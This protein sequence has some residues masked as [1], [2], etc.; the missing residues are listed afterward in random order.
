M[1][2]FH[3]IAIPH[4][5]VLEG[6]LTMDVFAA[7]LWQVT[8]NKGPEEY[9]DAETFFGK[10]YLT[11]GL[12]NLLDIVQKRLEGRGGDPV[13]QIQTP[14]GGG[15]THSLIAMYHKAAE[16]RAKTVAIVGTAPGGQKTLWGWLEEQLTGK[17]TTLSGLVSPGKIALMNLLEK[18]QPVLILMD[19]ILE[20]AVKA[21][22]TKV[23]ESTLAAQTLAFMQEL[24]ETVSDLEKT[25]LVVTIPSSVAPLYDQNAERLFKGLQMVAG[26][27]EKIYTPID[28]SEIASIIRSRLFSSCDVA[29]AKDVVGAFIA[30]AEREEIIPYGA[31]ASEYRDRFLASFPFMPEVID[32][33]YQR[34]GS[35]H[36]FQ[37]TRGVLRLL[38]LVLHSLRQSARPYVSLSD[39]EL[40]NQEIRQE[41]LKHIGSEFNSVIASDITGPTAGAQ[42]VNGSLGNAYRGLRLGTSAATSL[43]LYSF[44]GGHERGA[45]LSETKRS[46]T[47]TENP[48]SAIAEAVDQLKTGLFY[49][50]GMGDRLYFS[51]QPNLNRILLTQIENLRDQDVAE[52]EREL[53]GSSLSKQRLKISLWQEDPAVIQDT[54][55]L[56]LV[57]LR[58]H[59]E[60][61]MMSILQNKGQTPR[62]YRNALFFLYPQETEKTA[63]ISGLKRK[64]AYEGIEES[65][66]SSLSEEQKREIAKEIKRSRAG[67]NELM[68]RAYRMVAIPSKDGLREIDLG[69]PTYGENRSL[70]DGVYEKLRSEGHVLEKLAPLVIREKYLAD[71]EWVSTEA[72]YQSSLKTP[73]EPRPASKSAVEQGILEGTRNG[74]FGIGELDGNS[75]KCLFYKAESSVAFSGQEVLISEKKCREQKE[76][77]PVGPPTPPEP[78]TIPP[79]SPH[80]QTSRIGKTGI[81]L[82]FTIPK[83]KVSSL[84]GVMNYLQSRFESLEVRLAAEGGEITLQE[85]DDKVLEAFRQAGIEV[86]EG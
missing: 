28:D 32:V 64:M 7:D 77:G 84:M 2:P 51:N 18:H 75:A 74:L 34:W 50:Q 79:P 36:T 59:N 70:D 11:Q 13:I 12:Q 73:G 76:A 40:G 56:Q 15:K 83:G 68:R 39:F 47:T 45:T 35:F 53:L 14:F 26:R 71:K 55:A 16:W 69:I 54:D 24:G 80:A 27:V 82:S 1:K 5:D 29:K 19:E 9:R 78:A 8:R 3:T 37:R 25:C 43:F 62:V 41:L 20:Y 21:A 72:L 30:Y 33:L 81:H 58:N 67:L 85:Y 31:T 22:G 65:A 86:R 52:E 42:K 66:G 61:A 4:R 44:S 10:T 48:A 60:K 63:L 57:I 6:R 23:G 38:S 17:V 46:A 49:L